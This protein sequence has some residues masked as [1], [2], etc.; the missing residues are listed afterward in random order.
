MKNVTFGSPEDG[1]GFCDIYKGWHG[2]QRLC[3][4]VI[5]L[6]QKSDTDAALK[7]RFCFFGAPVQ[8][9]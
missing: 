3:L 8:L 6:F 9:I 4:K 5:R 2:E 7:V 1:G